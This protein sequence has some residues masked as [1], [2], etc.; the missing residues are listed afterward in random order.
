VVHSHYSRGSMPTVDPSE[1]NI[2]LAT[3]SVFICGQCF[4]YM[5]PSRTSV[6]TCACRVWPNILH[7][8]APALH[9]RPHHPLDNAHYN[10]FDSSEALVAYIFGVIIGPH[11]SALAVRSD[12]F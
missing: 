6:L 5:E 1:L 7:R 2:S 4:P 11:V 8:Q 10:M 3:L 12:A 9:V